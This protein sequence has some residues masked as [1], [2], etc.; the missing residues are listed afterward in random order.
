[1]LGKTALALGLWALGLGLWALVPASAESPQSP[2]GD[3]QVAFRLIVVSSVEK[4]QQIAD[5]VT[6]GGSFE[7]L[8]RAQSTDM[9]APQGGLIGPIALSEL[10]P[11][12]RDALRG[13]APGAVTAVLRLPT[14]FALVQRVDLLSGSSMRGGEI[15]AV[16][17]G[18][19]A[20]SRIRARRAAWP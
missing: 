18:I 9:S 1:M 13:L 20:W 14:G 3:P 4:A 11:E 8:A 19:K 7:A 2:Q 16:C 6:G 17:T 5:E 12:L 15:L 10:R